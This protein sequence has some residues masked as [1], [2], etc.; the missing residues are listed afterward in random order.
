MKLLTSFLLL[1]LT[2][3]SDGLSGPF[4]GERIPVIEMSI[5][6]IEKSNAEDLLARPSP[7][8]P[9]FYDFEN[10]PDATYTE[11]MAEHG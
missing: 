5:E 1:T 10:P 11:F 9:M 6:D 4:S 8:D 3:A 2:I 7:V